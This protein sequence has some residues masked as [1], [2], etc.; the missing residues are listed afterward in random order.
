[1]E[2]IKAFDD[3]LNLLNLSSAVQ[4]IKHGIEYSYLL[5][6][7]GDLCTLLMTVVTTDRVRSFRVASLI[8]THTSICS[9]QDPVVRSSRAGARGRGWSDQP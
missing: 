3:A 2:L 4:M 9:G 6:T 7:I 5:N 8:G 1:M